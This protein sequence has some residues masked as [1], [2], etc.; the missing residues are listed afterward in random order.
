MTEH[1]QHALIEMLASGLALEP[2]VAEFAA[3]LEAIRTSLGWSYDRLA[4]A[5]GVSKPCAYKACKGEQD[6]GGSK[7][8]ALVRAVRAGLRERARA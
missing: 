6:T 3:R 8:A 2:S 7:R 5:A 1:E 4:R